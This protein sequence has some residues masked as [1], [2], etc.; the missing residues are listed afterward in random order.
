MARPKNLY[1]QGWIQPEIACLDLDG[2]VSLIS[3]WNKHERDTKC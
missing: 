1:I 3:F 2:P